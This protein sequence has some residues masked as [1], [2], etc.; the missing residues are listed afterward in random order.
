MMSMGMDDRCEGWLIWD[1]DGGGLDRNWDWVYD[2]C[3]S[4]VYFVDMYI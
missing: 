4:R 1:G 2:V 3:V